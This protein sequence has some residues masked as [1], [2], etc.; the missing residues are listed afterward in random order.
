MNFTNFERKYVQNN[1]W[2]ISTTLLWKHNNSTVAQIDM[3]W[4]EN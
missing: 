1:S 2:D 4:M 3:D